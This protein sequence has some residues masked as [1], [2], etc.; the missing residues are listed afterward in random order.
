MKKRSKVDDLK[1]IRIL[2][3]CREIELKNAGLYSYFAE[4]FTDDRQISALLKKTSQEEENHAR[5]FDLLIKLIKENAI[6]SVSANLEETVR[7]YDFIDQICNKVR[8]DPPTPAE[9]LATAIDLEQYLVKFH[10]MAVTWFQDFSYQVL[11]TSLM[12]ADNDHV[13]ALTAAYVNLQGCSSDQEMLS[14]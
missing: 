1:C 5:Q 12:K 14:A 4:L 7:A 3:I 8:L 2:D 6:E 11:F 10:V 9:A 13:E